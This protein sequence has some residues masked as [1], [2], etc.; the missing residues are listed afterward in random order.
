MPHEPTR[1]LPPDEPT[2]P[3]AASEVNAPTASIGS[4]NTLAD[5][6]TPFAPA[7]YE[8]LEE[9]GSGGM[10][11]VFRAREAA[12]NRHVALKVLH[13]RYPACG[14]AADRF[15]E[16]SQITG[17]LQ[18]PGIPPV[19]QVGALPDGRPFLVMK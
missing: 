13:G 11:V 19:H 1:T 4:G 10:G 15:V 2:G 14:T 18:H 5:P 12:R 6:A 17:Q 8:L 3:A 7:G 9:V 16:E